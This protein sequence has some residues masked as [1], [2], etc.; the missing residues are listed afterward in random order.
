MTVAQHRLEGFPLGAQISLGWVH[1]HHWNR[2]VHERVDESHQ[3]Q[4]L[5]CVVLGEASHFG[6]CLCRIAPENQRMAVR[7]QIDVTRRHLHLPKTVAFQLQLLR[8]HRMHTQGHQIERAGVNQVLGGLWDQVAR[9]CHSA[10]FLSSLD[11]HDLLASLGQ[12]T[13]CRQPV[14]AAADDYDIVV[15]V[16]FHCVSSWVSLF[17][18]LQAGIRGHKFEH[19][20]RGGFLQRFDL[21]LKRERWGFRRNGLFL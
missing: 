17:C 7:M 15:L 12:I 21:E 2:H 3:G 19:I 16:F 4:E 14:M 9:G 20:S 8:H 1:P 5:G 18:L 10:N 13:G 6:G 11:D